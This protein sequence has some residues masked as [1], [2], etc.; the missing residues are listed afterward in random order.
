MMFQQKDI[1]VLIKKYPKSKVSA[2][3]ILNH[4]MQI[5][6][7]DTGRFHLFLSRTAPKFIR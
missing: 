3:I 5:S 1:T 7:L 4:N 2:D 6:P